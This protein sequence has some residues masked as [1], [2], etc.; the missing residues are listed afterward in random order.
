MRACIAGWIM[1]A[2]STAAWAQEPANSPTENTVTVTAEGYNRDDA[3]KR[4]MRSAL[5]RGAG[6]QLASFSDVADFQLIRDTIYSRAFG[7]ISNYDVVEEKEGAGGTVVIT[8]RATVRPDAV[9]Q[10]WGE[11]QNLLTQLGR[12]RIMVWI[13]EYIDDQLQKD[14]IV[15][16]RIEQMFVNAGFDLIAKDRIN[17]ARE[18]LGSRERDDINK[19]VELA[20]KA[21]AHIL[22]RGAAHANRAGIESIYGIPAAYYNCDVAARIFY[23]DTGKLLASESLP[24][25]RAGVRSRKEYSPQA[26]RAALVKATYRD[27]QDDNPR[28]K[29]PVANRIYESVMIQWST[30]ITAGGDIDLEVPGLPFSNYIKLKAALEDLT[31]VK[32]V[33]GEFTSGNG[34]FRIRADLT[35]ETLAIQ[36]TQPPFAE[37]LEVRDLKLNKIT[38]RA[39]E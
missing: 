9:A 24:Q 23:V 16:A 28:L 5:E 35:T 36:L 21:G 11:V 2:L 15:A 39:K 4:A 13:D 25:T 6:V 12:P 14:S 7:V 37:W 18:K 33:N 3:L 29:T 26:A 17:A 31:G 34:K 38:A 19:A 20:E 1:C 27:P 32:E 10:T 8:I 30:A 22:V